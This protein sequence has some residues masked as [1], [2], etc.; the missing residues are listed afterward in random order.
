MLAKK[1]VQLLGNSALKGMA[2][3]SIFTRK[4]YSKHVT[5]AD[6]LMLESWQRTGEALSSAMYELGRSSCVKKKEEKA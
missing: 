4:N 5:S 1:N 2:S 3:L 6:K